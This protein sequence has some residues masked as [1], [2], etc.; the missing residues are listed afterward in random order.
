MAGLRVA[1]SPPLK[2]WPASPFFEVSLS[3]SSMWQ[4]SSGKGIAEIE[5]REDLPALSDDDLAY[6]KLVAAPARY[7]LRGQASLPSGYE[8][9][10]NHTA[11]PTAPG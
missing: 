5:I 6:A 9:G 4:T 3:G 1:R 11:N 10:K 8:P 2:S 7:W